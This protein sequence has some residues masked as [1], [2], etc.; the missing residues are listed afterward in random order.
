MDNENVSEENI[1][2]YFEATQNMTD[3]ALKL[4][5]LVSDKFEIKQLENQI[6]SYLNSGNFTKAQELMQD[7]RLEMTMRNSFEYLYQSMLSDENILDEVY[8]KVINNIDLEAKTY[9]AFKEDDFLNE[10]K[11]IDVEGEL[12]NEILEE[13]KQEELEEHELTLGGE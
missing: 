8:E 13:M 12:M 1:K 3:E 4:N 11:K 10:M 5:E 7:E 2:A 6:E 9:E